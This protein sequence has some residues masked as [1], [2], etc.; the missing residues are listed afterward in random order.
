MYGWFAMRELLEAVYVGRSDC[1]LTRAGEHVAGIAA[2]SGSPFYQKAAQCEIA[3]MLSVYEAPGIDDAAEAEMVAILEGLWALLLGSY[4][5]KE[6]TLALRRHFGLPNLPDT[7][8]GCNGTPCLEKPTP[9]AEERD[10]HRTVK[11][12]EYIR[13]I[14]RVRAYQRQLPEAVAAGER[15]AI[16]QCLQATR[17]AQEVLEQVRGRLLTSGTLRVDPSI[18]S[19]CGQRVPV[20]F[21]D[22]MR[23]KTKGDWLIKLEEGD[24]DSLLSMTEPHRA[25]FGRLAIKGRSADP[26]EP[27]EVL[28]QHI[29]PPCKAAT[30]R[31][32]T[33][34]FSY[35][36]ESSQRPRQERHEAILQAH[37]SRRP[38]FFE[39]LSSDRRLGFD[40]DTMLSSGVAVQLEPVKKVMIFC[41]E[42]RA[43]SLA[44]LA[45]SI[46]PKQ[47]DDVDRHRADWH[48]VGVREDSQ[49]SCK[50][51][52]NTTP[53]I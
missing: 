47:D 8:V 13:A 21:I 28:R 43:F 16:P 3:A 26:N 2:G 40:G 38:V 37:A 41:A 27:G 1:M 36:P 12:A 49:A 10:E 22:G 32:W 44:W 17:Q 51:L 24:V 20:N 7:V 45:K 14:G 31:F 53:S 46:V 33:K 29:T 48:G 19:L 18:K 50:A 39:L 42:P 5:R 30:R 15:D 52:I 23:F 34:M 25:L 9:L 4:T 35:L 11:N 6:G